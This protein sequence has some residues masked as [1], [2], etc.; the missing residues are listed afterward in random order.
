MSYQWQ[1]NGEDIE[2]QTNAALDLTSVTL[3]MAG[4][5][6]VIASNAFGS[7]TGAVTTVSITRPTLVFD[8]TPEE[9]YLTNGLLKS[10]VSGLVGSG[11]AV[12]SVSSNF[13][14]WRPIL[15]NPP[16]VGNW[17]FIDPE[18]ASEA[19]RIYR[20]EEQEEE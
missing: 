7:A 6:R 20:A 8:P 2:G 12:I 5:Y 18:P 19:L 17:D 1:F 9:T 3:D 11:S 14:H 10:R 16:S 4:E 13:L 15:T